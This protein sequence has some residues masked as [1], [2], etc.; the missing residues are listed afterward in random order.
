VRSSDS[1]TGFISGAIILEHLSQYL[2][3]RPRDLLSS[4]CTYLCTDMIGFFVV[5]FFFVFFF[6]YLRGGVGL[7]Y[8]FINVSFFLLVFCYLTLKLEDK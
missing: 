7:S 1:D 4:Q 5:V 2:C 3:T 8:Y 6:V